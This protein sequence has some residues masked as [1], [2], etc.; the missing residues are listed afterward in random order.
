MVLL[1]ANTLRYSCSSLIDNQSINQSIESK[2]ANKEANKRGTMGMWKPNSLL[3]YLSKQQQQQRRRV[4][5][6]RQG[7]TQSQH[8]LVPQP[9]E[10]LHQ[11]QHQHQHQQEKQAEEEELQQQASRLRT[12]VV[13]LPV[14]VED[15][16]LLQKVETEKNEQKKTVSAECPPFLSANTTTNTTTTTNITSNNNIVTT[17]KEED[18][19]QDPTS[20]FGCHDTDTILRLWPLSNLDSG[21]NNK[22]KKTVIARAQAQERA[23]TVQPSRAKSILNVSAEQYEKYEQQQ[24]YILHLPAAVQEQE[25]PWACGMD[26]HFMEKSL[27]LSQTNS[28]NNNTTHEAFTSTPTAK[29]RRRHRSRSRANPGT[30]DTLPMDNEEQKEEVLEL[31]ALLKNTSTNTLP[32]T[33]KH[34]HHNNNNGKKKK[35][36]KKHTT[37]AEKD[38]VNQAISD[39]SL[40]LVPSTLYSD[41]IQAKNQQEQKSYQRAISGLFCYSI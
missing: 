28:N 10:P 6:R 41:Y 17:T 39:L 35:D 29:M 16:E 36:K 8:S 2:P 30:P 31:D 9:P 37:I 33:K 32:Q 19:E 22:T 34:R 4:Q 24:D 12:V 3:R 14:S 11:H 13:V 18:Y 25:E 5:R 26:P 40:G 15:I 27:H 1:F 20:A 21:R 38:I 7:T 23:Q